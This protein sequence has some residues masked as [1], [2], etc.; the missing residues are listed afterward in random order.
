MNRRGDS[1]L[2]ILVGAGLVATVI[3]AVLL[4]A[5]QGQRGSRALAEVHELLALRKLFEDQLM[6]EGTILTGGAV[7]VNPND[8]G[9][10]CNSTS[11]APGDQIA[12]F[13][14]LRRKSLDGSLQWFTGPLEADGGARLG[15]WV[16]RASCSKQ[17][18]GLVVRAR[19]L[20]STWAD[21][22][23][24]L[25]MGVPFRC[26][27]AFPSPE[28]N[29][30]NP[31]CRWDV[32]RD[33][34]VSPIDSLI[35][36]NTVNS[37]GAHDLVRDTSSDQ[38]G[39]VHRLPGDYIDVTGDKMVNNQDSLAV[40]NMINAKGSFRCAAKHREKLSWHN[41]KCRW[42]VNNSGTIE[43]MDSLIIINTLN[44][45]GAHALDPDTSGDGEG[46]V[47]ALPGEYVD[48]NDNGSVDNPDAQAVINYIN[49]NKA[50]P[51]P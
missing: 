50:G 12:P 25:G 4:H 8:L 3:V 18:G 6:C 44:S 30:Q 21:S 13:F 11:V 32:N 51:C 2:F 1:I 35:I 7:A 10:N 29:W 14:R 26:S 34:W 37:A 46:G 5:N 33:G 22:R 36:I 40:I 47:H 48:V 19:T 28:M 27:R 23:L 43:P 9:N 15:K 41:H 38:I 45:F 42:D 39:G 20:A 31:L 49:V 16:V 24:V 17:E